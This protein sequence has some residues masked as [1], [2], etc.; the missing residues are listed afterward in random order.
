V[1]DCIGYAH[2]R[3]RARIALILQL[4]SLT[5][6]DPRCTPLPCSWSNWSDR[7]G[8]LEESDVAWMNLHDLIGRRPKL[9]LLGHRYTLVLALLKSMI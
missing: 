7:D 2:D 6:E 9:P 5:L 8:Q 1:L 3:Y 4:L